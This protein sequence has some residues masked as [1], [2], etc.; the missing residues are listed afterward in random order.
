M[1]Q[2]G[3]AASARAEIVVDLDAIR[4]NVG[5]L[6]EL[7]APT[8]L[9]AVVK[10]DGYGHGMVECSRAARAAGADWLGV[11]TL[12]EALALRE[13]GDRGPLLCWLS[14]PG[15]DY[16]AAVAADI[17]LTA[18]TCRTL[19][20][21]AAAGSPDR[22]VKV[23]IKVDTGLSRG[24]AARVEWPELFHCAA[25]HQAAGRIVV[26]GLWSHFASADTPEDPANDEQERSFREAVAMAHE[27][28]L[29]PGLLH[30]ANSAAAILRPSARFDLVRCGIAA[31]GLDPAPG[32]DHRT[33]LRP[34]MT[35]RSALAL[36]KP[37]H[38]G[39]G[40]S[41]GHAWRAGHDTTVGVVP[42]GYAEGVS[43]AAG[44]KVDVWVEGRRR[45]IRGRVCMD[46]FVIDLDGDL[47]PAGT[48]VVVFGPGEHGE[49]TAQEW[50]EATG[51]INYE[52]VTRVGGRLTRRFVGGSASTSQ[53]V[54]C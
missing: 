21:L 52:I 28:G 47:P 17:E 29:E 36:A 24:G 18:S 30:L 48:D 33:P 46:Q 41:Y 13:S 14:V 39:D 9:M 38:R 6:R 49:P 11:A 35:V 43:R 23:Q 2:P 40:V 19:D 32:T 51:T 42:M 53:E 44:N 1:P 15:E 22:P 8:K 10:A 26:T 16:V 7:V 45:P 27:C 12:D 5:V 20:E 34:A 54:G 4:H 3:T 50:A 25:A 37:I 31:Y